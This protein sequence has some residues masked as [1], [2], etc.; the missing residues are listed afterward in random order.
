MRISDWSSDVCSSDLED[1]AR[2]LFFE[3]ALPGSIIVNQAG[4]R[5]TNEAASYHIVGREM[6]EKNLPGA[7]TTPAY[8]IFDATFRKKYPMG[9]VRSDERRVGHECGSTFM[10]RW[11]PYH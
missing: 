10:S 4:K 5:F 8:V 2:P 11:S 7:E 6:F 3:R 1:R 9:R